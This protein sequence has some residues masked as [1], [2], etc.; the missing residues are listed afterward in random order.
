M[1]SVP[2]RKPG[3]SH[4]VEQTSPLAVLSRVVA[5]ARNGALPSAFCAGCPAA[6]ESAAFRKPGASHAFE[7]PSPYGHDGGIRRAVQHRDIV[8]VA[9]GE[10]LPMARHVGFGLFVAPMK[11]VDRCESEIGPP[12][13]REFRGPTQKPLAGFVIVALQH[14]PVGEHVIEPHL[15]APVG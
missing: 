6:R 8:Q 3:A 9:S 15:P 12:I 14:R 11:R 10:Q 5:T 4:A 13:V 7:H 1:E 2:F